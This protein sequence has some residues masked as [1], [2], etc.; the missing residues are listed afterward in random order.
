MINDKN[1]YKQPKLYVISTI[2]F[3]IIAAI[4]FCWQLWE[5]LSTS[6]P[7]D[8][9]I[10]G[11]FGDFVGGTLGVVFSMIGVIFV[12]F[13]FKSQQR[14]AYEQR[15]NDMFFETLRMYHEQEKELQFKYKENIEGTAYKGESNYK[16]FFDRVKKRDS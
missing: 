14:T 12:V 11:Q 2:L 3:F 1:L 13:T 8:H 6:R 10:W 5:T 4:F 16:D 15:F 9:A 7:I